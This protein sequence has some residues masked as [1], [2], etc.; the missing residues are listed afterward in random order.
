MALLTGMEIEGVIPGESMTK[1]RGVL[2]FEKPPM[3]A[4][5]EVGVQMV[6]DAVT[7]PKAARKL[8]KTLEGGV[9]IDVVV[10]SMLTMLQGEGIVSPQSLMLMAPALMTMIEGMATIAKVPVKYSEQPDEWV[11]PD[12]AEVAALVSK[13][14][15]QLEEI[16]PTG[17]EELGE[18]AG[19]AVQ[20]DVGLMTPPQEGI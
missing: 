7:K 9:P 10:D 2:P 11:E 12:E 15:G 4:S 18:E 17:D 20:Q 6:F 14:T 16:A 8:I 19:L 3:T 5:P 13:M 1:P